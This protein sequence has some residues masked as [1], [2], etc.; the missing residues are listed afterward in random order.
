MSEVQKQPQPTFVTH[1]A[2]FVIWTTELIVYGTVGALIAA[3]VFCLVVYQSLETATALGIIAGFTLRYVIYI[4]TRATNL[5]QV[6]VKVPSLSELTF[7]VSDQGRNVAWQ[8]F[9]EVITR[10]STQ[11]LNSGVPREALTSLYGLFDTTRKNL[12]DSRPSTRRTDGPTVERLAIVMLNKELRPFLSKWHARLQTFE[13][14]HKNQPNAKWDSEEE[15][16]KELETLQENMH[17]Y[18]RGFARLAQVVESDYIMK[19]ELGI[20]QSTKKNRPAS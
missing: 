5:T 4:Y 2:R 9:V 1:I 18:A 14:Q 17:E 6:K 7:I 20:D 13:Q 11:K 8:L 3:L 12:K 15:F 10:I 19:L 16:R